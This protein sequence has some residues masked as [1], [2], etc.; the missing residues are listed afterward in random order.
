MPK[1][2]KKYNEFKLNLM[3]EHGLYGIGYCSNT[4]RE[5]YFDMNDYDLIKDYC[6]CEHIM[7]DGYCALETSMFTEFNCKKH[8][9][10]HYLI[11]GKKYDHIDRNPFNNRRHN[12][13]AATNSQNSMNRSMRDDNSSGVIGVS[14]KKSNQK[15][16][17]YICVDGKQIYIGIFD[18][19]NDAIIERLKAEIKYFG[20]FAPQKHLYEQYGINTTE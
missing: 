15:W 5:F 3:D 8:L 6:W 16:V 7:Q 9:R 10:M 11:V 1:F 4:G 13:R 19:K 2:I 18:N 14:W 20:E 17:S 12:L